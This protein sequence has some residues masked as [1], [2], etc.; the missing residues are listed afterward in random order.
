MISA[1]FMFLKRTFIRDLG[2]QE[3][4]ISTGIRYN[5]II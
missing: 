2:I 3:E 1:N 4:F 5:N